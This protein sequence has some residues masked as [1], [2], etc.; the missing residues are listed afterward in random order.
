MSELNTLYLDHHDFEKLITLGYREG[1]ISHHND[2]KQL[3]Q[4]LINENR[5]SNKS[6]LLSLITLYDSLDS[7]D[8]I[9]DLKGFL[10]IGL[11]KPDCNLISPDEELSIFGTEERDFAYISAQN[12]IKANSIP[13]A[14]YIINNWKILPYGFQSRNE[15]GTINRTAKLIRQWANG[16]YPEMS[17]DQFYLDVNIQFQIFFPKLWDI[18]FLSQ[19]NNSSFK[20]SFNSNIN[21]ISNSINIT[22]SQLYMVKT[23]LEK[24][25]LILPKPRNIRE[26]VDLRESN[27]MSRFRELLSSWLCHLKKGEDKLEKKIRKDIALAN[28]ELK[29]SKHWIEYKQS[30][31]N[32]WINSIGGHIPILSNILTVI[33]TIGG[34]HE[35]RVE[36]KLSWTRIVEIKKK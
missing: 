10:N 34:L 36:K 1:L 8:T 31:V 27:E 25:V 11:I 2:G 13:L 6:E 12:I 15:I 24:E 20:S 26:A 19:K 18:I 35:K 21:K 5:I 16:E 14:R 23:K 4:N 17:N 30:P 32:F 33:G 3:T 9:Y 29:I 28:R 7:S 22:D